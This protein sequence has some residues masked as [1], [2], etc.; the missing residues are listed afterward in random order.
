MVSDKLA[1]RVRREIS[2]IKTIE[3]KAAAVGYS[4]MSVRPRSLAI[5]VATLIRF[6]ICLSPAV[7]KRENAHR[8]RKPSVNTDVHD[9]NLKG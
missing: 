7:E 8:R 9:L 4:Q 6:R 3:T 2:R 5:Q 1:G